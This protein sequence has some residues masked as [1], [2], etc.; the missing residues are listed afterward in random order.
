MM[1]G[2]GNMMGG[3]FGPGMGV[4]FLVLLVVLAL[5]GVGAVAIIKWASRN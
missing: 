5:A 2:A 4:G 1:N 3:Y